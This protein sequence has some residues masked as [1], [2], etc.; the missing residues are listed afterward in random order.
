[1]V[2]MASRRPNA[3]SNDSHQADEVTPSGNLAQGFVAFPEQHHR[4]GLVAIRLQQFFKQLSRAAWP[5]PTFYLNAGPVRLR[6]GGWV[7]LSKGRPITTD[8]IY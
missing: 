7:Q 4:D 6:A 1:M 3:F 5:T 2:R 8:E